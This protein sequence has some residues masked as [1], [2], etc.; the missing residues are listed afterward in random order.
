L[1][2]NNPGKIHPLQIAKTDFGKGKGID[3]TV[4]HFLLEHDGNIDGFRENI[5][6]GKITI[7][8]D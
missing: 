3:E 4:E 8:D 7:Q 2:E 1:S 5:A 6:K